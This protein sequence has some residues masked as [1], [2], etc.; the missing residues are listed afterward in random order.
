MYFP[1]L[2][3]VR[4]ELAAV[5]ALIPTLT[6][7][8]NSIPILEPVKLKTT[9]LTNTLAAVENAQSN[10]KLILILNPSVGEKPLMADLINLANTYPIKIIPAFMAGNQHNRG[11]ATDFANLVHADEVAI[12]HET[13]NAQAS[14]DRATIAATKRIIWDI[15][16]KRLPVS[17]LGTLSA[18]K[19]YIED[20]F[21]RQ[22]RNA[23]YPSDDF[24]SDLHTRPSPEGY[25]HFGDYTIMPKEYKNGGGPAMAVALH[26]LYESPP[27]LRMKHFVSDPVLE[28]DPVGVKYGDA[29]T[30][31][32]H[33]VN[34]DPLSYNSIGTGLYAANPSFPG[35]GKAKEY[36]IMHH[37][38]LRNL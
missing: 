31:L 28:P 33:F 37:I 6:A 8:N 16:T 10:L 12:I 34:T 4:H 13:D 24:F 35:L 30:K 7:L 23:D 18:N 26:L 5:R 15:S 38:E 36:S 3:A 17:Y 2:R 14:A 1:Y 27:I 19:V 9:D 32:L 22:Q 25:I 11:T 21:S 29:R 20:A